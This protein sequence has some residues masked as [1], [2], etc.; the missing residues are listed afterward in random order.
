MCRKPGIMHKGKKRMT[1]LELALFF[2]VHRNTMGKMLRESKI[3]L[4][5]PSAILDFALKL[6]SVQAETCFDDLKLKAHQ[7]Q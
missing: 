4:S 2:N 5:D 7:M 6:Y 1:C 3:D